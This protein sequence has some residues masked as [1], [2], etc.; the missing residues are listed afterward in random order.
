[1]AYCSWYLSQGIAID[2]YCS[3]EETHLTAWTCVAGEALFG[4]VYS[5]PLCGD[6]ALS[7]FLFS[8][9]SLSFGWL[10]QSSGTLGVVCEA[11]LGS[12]KC[13]K[14]RFYL[15]SL[16]PARGYDVI[17]FYSFLS[18]TSILQACPVK[19][20][21]SIE[22]GRRWWWG[23]TTQ[24]ASLVKLNRVFPKG[25]KRTKIWNELEGHPEG[26]GFCSK[27]ALLPVF[28]SERRMW[29]LR[30]CSKSKAFIAR[31]S[32]LKLHN[33]VRSLLDLILEWGD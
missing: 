17:F 28:S 7:L 25:E 33:R 19:L 9:P 5:F 20:R 29:G 22:E 10:A 4:W 3:A 6:H 2:L 11:D 32:H 13:F 31:L 8:L 16:W 12:Q 26:G 14:S 30:A 18:G 21:H 24:T 23:N 15:F 27:C 1:M